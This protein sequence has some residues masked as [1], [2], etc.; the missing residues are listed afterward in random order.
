[1]NGSRTVG[2][3]LHG[4]R[5]DSPRL[6]LS[7]LAALV[8]W[9]FVGRKV[10]DDEFF[11]V[12][13][14]AVKSDEPTPATGLVLRIPN[15]LVFEAANPVK[16]T[17][18]VVGKG[19]E[20]DR[21]R[22]ELLGV[23]E[24]PPDFC[25]EFV[26]VQKTIDI[27][28]AFKFAGFRTLTSLAIDGTPQITIGIGKRA[29]ARVTT[30]AEKFELIGDSLPAEAQWTIAP[31]SVEVAGA[32]DLV[33]RLASTGAKLRVKL[34]RNE[35]NYALKQ[36]RFEFGGDSVRLVEG[37]QEIGRVEF[38]APTLLELRITRTTEPRIVRLENL[39]IGWLNLKSAWREG[40]DPADPVRTTPA[41]MWIE[42]T[43]TGELA[44]VANLEDDLRKRINLFVDLR[45]LGL[46]VEAGSLPVRVE[47]LPVGASIALEMERVDVELRRKEP[48]NSEGGN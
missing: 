37:D 28:D 22:R 33:Q 18:R 1:M 17:L 29:T 16:V 15:G 6:V 10:E 38:V 31:S 4:L 46:T 20:I 44:S 7:L 48:E 26:R 12:N 41:A 14:I 30:G 32:Q 35:V 36:G 8:L 24:V 27:K 9:Y 11:A 19:E 3:Y 5:E 39:P 13:V 45:D 34:D 2:A 42:I 21:L 23:Y 43:A 25:G 40:L 47:G